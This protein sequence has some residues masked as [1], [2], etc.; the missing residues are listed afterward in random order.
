MVNTAHCRE[1]ISFSRW[2]CSMELGLYP[3]KERL[4][5]DV[6][7][8][9]DQGVDPTSLLRGSEEEVMAMQFS[10]P[11]LQLIVFTIS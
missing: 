3:P 4:W 11:I 6:S 8:M 7:Q 9:S 2:L 10:F 5:S 1:N